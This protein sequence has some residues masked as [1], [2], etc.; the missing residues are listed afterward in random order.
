MGNIVSPV[1]HLCI[2]LTHVHMTGD[3]QRELLQA[4][5]ATV[6]EHLARVSR[7]YKVV[8]ITM[9]PNNGTKPRPEEAPPPPKN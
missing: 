1:G 3:A 6:V 2:D 8:T 9:A 5:E 4:V 7:E